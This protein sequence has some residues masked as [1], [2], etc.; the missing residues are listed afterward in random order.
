LFGWTWNRQ[1]LLSDRGRLGRWGE[2]RCEK[3]LKGRG[4]TKLAGNFSCAG[5]EIDLIMADS[6]GAII[7]V[8]VKTRADEDFGP[9]EAVVTP[10]KRARLFKAARYFLSIHNIADRPLRFDVVVVILPPRG[11]IEIRH[12]ENAF[13]P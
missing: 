6:Q 3:F 5:G 8:E 12:Y 2:K 13:V 7:F 1:K 11:R 4:C 9:T 10:A